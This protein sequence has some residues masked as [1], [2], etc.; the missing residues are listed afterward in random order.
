MKAGTEIVR[1]SPITGASAIKNSNSGIITT[2]MTGIMT[3]PE[4]S[5]RK[6]IDIYLL[7]PSG[8]MVRLAFSIPER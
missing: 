2:A 1:T 6:D 4:N 5:K 3:A 8:P 7:K